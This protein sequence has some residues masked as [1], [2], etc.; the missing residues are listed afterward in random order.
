MSIWSKQQEKVKDEQKTPEEIYAS[1][2]W[3]GFRFMWGQRHWEV[4]QELQPGTWEV[5]PLDGIEEHRV[6]ES[7]LYQMLANILIKRLKAEAERR[8]DAMTVFRQFVDQTRNAIEEV[9]EKD[10]TNGLNRLL[11]TIKGTV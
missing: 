10:R 8:N 7:F 6:L 1:G 11:D 4:V 3:T 2:D 5:L 9:P